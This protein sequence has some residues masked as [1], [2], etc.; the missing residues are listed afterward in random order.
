M[1][2]ALITII[3]FYGFNQNLRPGQCVSLCVC[4]GKRSLPCP[5]AELQRRNEI[6]VDILT[7]WGIFANS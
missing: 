7:T 6:S 2:A 1:V 3:R 4:D 5:D